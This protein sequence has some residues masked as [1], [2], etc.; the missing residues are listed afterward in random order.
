MSREVPVDESLC[1]KAAVFGEKIKE[2]FLYG[3]RVLQK[4]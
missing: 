2:A 3:I 4:Y 1:C